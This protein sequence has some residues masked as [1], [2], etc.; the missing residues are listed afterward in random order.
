M[1]RNFTLNPIIIFILIICLGAFASKDY[2]AG[3]ILALLCIVFVIISSKQKIKINS[4]TSTNEEY[5][6]AIKSRGD[7]HTYY[8]YMEKIQE[9][10]KID[11]GKSLD[12]VNKTIPILDG[13]VDNIKKSSYGSFDI[14]TIPAIDVG[15]RYWAALGD[16]DKLLIMKEA[17]EN[18][19]ELHKWIPYI[20]TAFSDAELAKRIKQFLLDNPGAL[21]N[22]L[23]KNLNVSG[24]DTSRIIKTLEKI[25]LVRRESI[26][27]TYKIYL[28]KF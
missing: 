11:I 10:E 21:Q 18:K 1:F 14:G 20:E 5:E 19:K 27:K 26:G 9:Y 13:F 17:V 15:C 4:I 25:G 2:L 7:L 22:T 23:S 12:Y 24:R 6:T 16:Y 3:T 28:E 8:E